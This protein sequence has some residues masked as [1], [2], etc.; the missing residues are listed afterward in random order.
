[1]Q[2]LEVL[3]T[4]PKDFD[5]Q[6]EVAAC[7]IEC[8][9]KLLLLQ[10]APDDSE[11]GSWGVPAGKV[12]SNE[13]PLQGAMRELFEET[14]IS[15]DSSQIQLIGSLYIRKPEID[16]VYHLFRIKVAT[17]LEVQLSHEH[18]NYQ[19]VSPEE[20]EMM[21]I[22]IGGKEAYAHYRALA[23]K[24]RMGAS[25][26]AYLVLKQ[27]NKILLLLR[28]NTGYC[29]GMWSFVAGHVED[30]ESATEGMCREAY[31]EIGIQINP[32]QLRV[33]HVMHRKS[34][35][36]NVDIFFECLSWEG[37]IINR[38]P[39]K[40]ECLAF[41][42]LDALPVNIVDYNVIALKAILKENFYSE[43]GWSS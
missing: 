21:P 39:D 43:Y 7:Y 26:N 4:K 1:M 28:K 34:S 24:K 30:G 11:A 32:L 14:G 31:E 16:Y 27:E 35:R 22:M 38:E 6:A 15:I 18:Q 25:V 37:N 12:E 42:S 8:E 3:K 36:L 19:W 29:D 5:P 9:G 2:T 17:R 10:N 20:I 23:D 40:C 33:V 13:T 41:F